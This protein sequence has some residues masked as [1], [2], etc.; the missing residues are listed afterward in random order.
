M[1]KFYCFLISVLWCSIFPAHSQII[2]T[3]A[4]NTS[5]TLPG[6]GGSATL[7]NIQGP[8]SITLDHLG[9]LYI[10]DQYNNRVRKVTT[11]GIISTIAGTGTAGYSGDGFAATSA[12]LNQPTGVAVDLAGNVFVSDRTNNVIRKI[13][14][15]GIISTYAGVLS[16]GNYGGDGNPATASTVFLHLPMGLAVDASGNLY[17]AELGNEIIRMVS[18]SGIISTFAGIPLTAGY[19][20]DLAVATDARFNQPIDVKVDGSGNVYIA[21]NSNHAIRKIDATGTITTITGIGSPGFAGDGGQATLAK[22]Y[23]PTGIALGTAGEI[24]VSDASNQR[25]REIYPSGVIYTLG[26]TGTTGYTGDGGLAHYANFHYP[27]GGIVDPAGNFYFADYANNVIRRITPF[28]NHAPVFVSGSSF[29]KNV[30][31]TSTN[32]TLDA[33]LFVNDLDTNQTVNWFVLAAPLHGTAGS[34]ASAVTTGATIAPMGVWYTPTAGY[35]GPDMFTIV[36][37]DGI[38]SNT[39][40]VHINVQPVLTTPVLSGQDSVCQL[41]T[42]L[43]TTLDTGG[44]WTSVNTTLATI[45]ATGTVTGINRGLDTIIYS[46]T[47]TCGS[48]IGMKSVFVK[49]HDTCLLQA[50]EQIAVDFGIRIYPDPCSGQFYCKVLSG[51]DEQVHLTLTDLVGRNIAELEGR[52][53]QELELIVHVPNGQ[54]ILSARTIEGV[55]TSRLQVVK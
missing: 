18:S 8:Y 24:F 53:N 52:T 10:A 5:S 55:F 2:S 7:A 44:T 42:I 36:A 28:H 51:S 30:C 45:S 21:D 37:T 9:N 1:K 54:Y 20:G 6:D 13:N 16:M 49:S 50:S 33:S 11:T 12:K 23:G 22:L 41:E 19:S 47:N 31:T 39:M 46:A 3:V 40:T 14:T 4:G 26:G 15:A 17:I 38:D 25:I 32:D 43:L 27:Y 34:L 35:A 29:T 48:V